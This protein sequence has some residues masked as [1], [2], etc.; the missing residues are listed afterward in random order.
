MVYHSENP[1]ARYTFPILRVFETRGDLQERNTA[2]N[3]SH[4]YFVSKSAQL[5]P[6]VRQMNPVHTLTP[7]STWSILDIRRKMSIICKSGFWTLSIVYIPIKLQR[8]GSWIFFRLQVKRKDRIPLVVGPP[9]WTSLRPGQLNQ[10][11]QQLGFLS[12]PF[13][14]K[15]G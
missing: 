8:F 1:R 3:E 10:G 2:Y 6:I 13:Y 4:L 11:A 9:G 14:L 7:V 12:F 5:N 15:T